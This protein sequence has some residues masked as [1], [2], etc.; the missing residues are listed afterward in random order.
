MLRKFKSLLS[1]AQ[2]AVKSRLEGPHTPETPAIA[3]VQRN[4]DSPRL[5]AKDDVLQR[6]RIAREIYRVICN[7]AAHHSV[8]IGLFGDWG[9][10][11]TTI[12]HWVAEMAEREAQIVIWF[13]PWSVRDISDLWLSFSLKLRSAL[14]QHG[15]TLP[16]ALEVKSVLAELRKDYGAVADSVGGGKVV[17]AIGGFLKFSKADI[18]A[19]KQRLRGRRVVVIIDDI[20]RADPKLLP[21]LLLSL[22]ELLDAPGFAFLVPFEKSIVAN[23]LVEQ[24]AAWGSGERFLEKI[25][26]FQITIPQ[27]T[28]D[29][30]WDLFS[31]NVKDFVLPQALAQLRPLSEFLPDNPR[32]IKR[33]ARMFELVSCETKRHKVDEIDWISLLMGF[34]IKLESEQFFQRYV[35]ET[36]RDTQARL[37]ESV[38]Q[39]EDRRAEA[40]E[41]RITN[42]IAAVDIDD[43]A[44]NERLKTLVQRWE[45]ERSYWHDARV[46]YTLRIFDLPDAFTW[47]EI[48]QMIAKWE[49][50]A[51]TAHLE[52]L[53]FEKAKELSQ[54]RSAV[55]KQLIDALAGKYH[56]R[57]EAAASVFL[58]GNHS[59]E[60]AFARALLARIDALLFSSA[61]DLDARVLA[62]EKFLA[63]YSTWAHFTSN[64]IDAKLREL[65]KR[66][67]SKLLDGAGDRWDEYA[68]R[69][70]P[71]DGPFEKDEFNQF[72]RAAKPAFNERALEAALAVFHEEDGAFKLL[73]GEIP[74]MSQELFF[75]AESALWSGSPNEA[76]IERV[77]KEAGRKPEVQRNAHHFLDMATG[78]HQIAMARS[79]ADL[80]AFLR[81]ERPSVALWNAAIAQPIQYRMLSATR[82]IRALLCRCGIAE[83]LL[84]FPEWLRVGEERDGAR[85]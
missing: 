2:D 51:Q 21:P 7:Q 67:L 11:K 3:H 74:E 41:R 22:R 5:D 46:I 44:V 57:L 52:Q 79:T 49:D 76:P 26:D 13:N 75:D 32:R 24:H 17:N 16:S 62:F 80:Q 82:R 36:F 25:L 34:M 10:G 37:A 70:K 30:R 71:N 43:K 45:K 1:I 55:L 19:L 60:V 42:L 29:A 9:Y 50:P 66:L 83:D 54:P 78:R 81:N 61:C 8:R 20:D 27:S 31:S 6:Y 15:V 58:Q 65:E 23:S 77:L 69:L 64:E 72:V 39:E 18:D 12:A 85:E 84:L 35:E 56:E 38:M 40:A 48:D 59:S 68:A 33:I 73:K 53:I 4:L 63:T 14:R 28:I 47:A